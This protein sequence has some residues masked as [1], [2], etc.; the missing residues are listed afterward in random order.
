MSR[1]KEQGTVL[2]GAFAAHIG[3]RRERETIQGQLSRSAFQR[4]CSLQLL[5][6]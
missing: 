1:G 5:L 6:E 2:I 3:C 4:S